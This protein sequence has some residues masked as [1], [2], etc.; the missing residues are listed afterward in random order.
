MVYM[1]GA[2]GTGWNSRWKLKKGFSWGGSWKSK[3]V[4]VGPIRQSK[5]IDASFTKPSSSPKQEK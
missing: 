4:N 1:M 2:Q 3:H 5:D